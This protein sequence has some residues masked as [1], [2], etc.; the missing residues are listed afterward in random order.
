MATNAGAAWPLP[1]GA[2]L[3]VAGRTADPSSGV[4]VGFSLDLEPRRSRSISRVTLE[5]LKKS[6][7]LCEPPGTTGGRPRELLALLVAAPDN[8]EAEAEEASGAAVLA[9]REAEEE[10]EEEEEEDEEEEEAAEDNGEGRL[11]AVPD[12]VPLLALA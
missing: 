11:A 10:E 7:A 8:A 4:R 3:L 1:G 5:V 12:T 6:A 2:L 9:D